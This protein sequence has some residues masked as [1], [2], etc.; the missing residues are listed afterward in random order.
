MQRPPAIK[1]TNLKSGT[2]VLALSKKEQLKAASSSAPSQATGEEFRGKAAARLAQV[3]G[4]A[5]LPLA[6]TI[7]NTFL[8]INGSYEA[9]GRIRSLISAVKGNPALRDLVVARGIAGATTLASEDARDWA[10]ANI[11]AKR[12]DWARE[13][14]AEASATCSGFK[15]CPECGGKATFEVGRSPAF[16]MAKNYTEYRCTELHCGKKTRVSE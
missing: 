8:L 7:V 11:K 14:L 6:E 2:Q 3:L 4:T 13:A 16:K 9:P 15:A 10:N 5:Q 12:E 1:K